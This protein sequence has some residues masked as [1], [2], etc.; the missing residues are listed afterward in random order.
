MVCGSDKPFRAGLSDG[1][2][3]KRV[4]Q[5]C[6]DLALDD[7]GE[8]KVGFQIGMKNSHCKHLKRLEFLGPLSLFRVLPSAE[9]VFVFS[10]GRRLALF[11]VLPCAAC[12]IS[13]IV[14]RRCRRVNSNFFWFSAF[15]C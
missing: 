9:V 10:P 5:E 6:V 15:F 3:S 4:G 1:S 13:I 11:Q 2:L 12:E 14:W 7:S 8:T